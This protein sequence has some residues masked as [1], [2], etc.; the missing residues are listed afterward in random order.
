MRE[1]LDEMRSLHGGRR[2][3]LHHAVSRAPNEGWDQG[4]G[5][6]S[7]DMM[8]AHLPPPSPEDLVLACGPH[9]MIVEV[10]K[11]G[12]QALGWDIDTQLVIF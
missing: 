7:R 2:F 1:E 12:L 9:P 5:H 4:S 11:P 3:K 6:V 8:A 10:V